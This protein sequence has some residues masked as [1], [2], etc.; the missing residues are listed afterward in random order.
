MHASA[1]MERKADLVMGPPSFSIFNFAYTK[2][3]EEPEIKLR[4][5]WYSLTYPLVFSVIFL[6]RRHL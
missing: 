2:N 5:H 3:A 1:A 4:R 6:E